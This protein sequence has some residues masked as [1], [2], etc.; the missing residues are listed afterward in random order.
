MAKPT[1]ARI[2]PRVEFQ[3]GDEVMYAG[4]TYVRYGTIVRLLGEGDAQMVE[5]EFED[6]RKELKKARD[7]ALRLLR[8]RT[9]EPAPRDYYDRETEEVRRSEIHRR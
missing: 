7:R 5:I 1:K 9:P 6:G 2:K 3:V 8:R 4:A